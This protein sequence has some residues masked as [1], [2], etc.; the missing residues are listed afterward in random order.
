MIFFYVFEKMIIWI[1]LLIFKQIKYFSVS[2]M[3]AFQGSELY[4][5]EINFFK[6]FK[7]I[8]YSLP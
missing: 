4:G 7:M 5:E 1:M 2:I 8:C 6:E 3:Y